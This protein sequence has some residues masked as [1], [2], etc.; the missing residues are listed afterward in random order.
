MDRLTLAELDLISGTVESAVDRTAEIDRWCSGPDWVLPVRSGFDPH[1]E[2]L[3]WQ[4]ETGDGP[5]FGLCRRF[6]LD[7][8]RWVVAGLE[9]MWGFAAPLVGM[10]VTSVAASLPEILA[11]SPWDVVVLPGL[12]EPVHQ[13]SYL[14]RVVGGVAPLGQV[15]VT[16]GMTRR[17]ADVSDGFD[18]W[19]RRRSAR[20]ARNLR[21]IERRAAG[22]GLTIEDIA[23]DADGPDGAERVFERILAVER[24]SWK[25]V[26]DQGLTGAGMEP[27]YRA[28]MVR[29]AVEGRLRVAVA[30][31]GGDD[32][33]YIIGGVRS[34]VYRGLQ[35]GYVEPARPWSVGHLLQLHQL[36]VAGADPTIDDYDLGMDIAYKEPW[37]DR[38]PRSYRLVIE[39]RSKRARPGIH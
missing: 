29:L 14:P 4:V 20:F 8:G 7:D 15:G 13:A 35:L 34:R 24:R 30:R 10:D 6:E 36:R 33:G 9:P 1:S 11:D 37:S 19:L 32:V 27:T 16:E 38:T 2:P 23:A 21:R 5:G 3:V 39:R 26:D 18:P 12:P 31:H 22:A 28:M 25:G 17:V